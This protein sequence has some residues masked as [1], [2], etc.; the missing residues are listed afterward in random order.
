MS[1]PETLVLRSRNRN[2]TLLLASL[3]T[4]AAPCLVVFSVASASYSSMQCEQCTQPYRPNQKILV[5]TGMCSSAELLGAMN[6]P[7]LWINVV[8]NGSDDNKQVIDRERGRA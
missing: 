8:Q 2:A 5:D 7:K 4:V 6:D 1:M 3:L